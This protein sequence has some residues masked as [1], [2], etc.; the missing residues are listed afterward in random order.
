MIRTFTEMMAKD[1]ALSLDQIERTN[2]DLFDSRNE[3]Y[4]RAKRLLGTAF[5]D[6]ESASWLAAHN[7]ARAAG[8]PEHDMRRMAIHNQLLRSLI[9]MDLVNRI[10]AVEQNISRESQ[11]DRH[12]GL[13][14]CS[15]PVEAAH[16]DIT[17]RRAPPGNEG[18]SVRDE[19]EAPLR[20]LTLKLHA[21]GILNIIALS[22]ASVVVAYLRFGRGWHWYFALPIWPVLYLGLPVAIGLGQGVAIRIRGP[23]VSI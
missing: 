12:G 20:S 22:L 23:H 3:E 19:H 10:K 18:G 16:I 21:T 15:E 17:R 13:V 2:I 9:D 4:G 6:L 14:E 7:V 1:S 8:I 5:N 11:R